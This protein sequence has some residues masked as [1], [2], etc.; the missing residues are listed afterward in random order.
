MAWL[1]TL[2][3]W[4]CWFKISFTRLKYIPYFFKKPSSNRIVRFF[5]DYIYGYALIMLLCFVITILIF[6]TFPTLPKEYPFYENT[7]LDTLLNFST[8]MFLFFGILGFFLALIF[9]K[10]T[11]IHYVGGFLGIFFIPSLIIGNGVI[12]GC[13]Y[14]IDVVRYK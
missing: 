6:S 7:I 3:I 10:W 9:H 11:K 5:D 8:S 12:I 14:L 4:Y 2:G 1:T 13:F